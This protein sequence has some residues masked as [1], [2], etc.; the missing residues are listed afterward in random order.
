MFVVGDLHGELGKLNKELTRVGFDMK[1]EHL[2]SVGDLVDRGE[3]SLGCLSLLTQEWFHAVRGNHEQMMIDAV[4]GHDNGMAACW[5]MNGGVW[6]QRLDEKERKQANDLISN[7]AAK[8]PYWIEVHHRGRVIVVCHA[9]WPKGDYILHGKVDSEKI[10]W[11]RDRIKA[12]VYKHQHSGIS[13][14]DLFVFGH[15]PLDEKVY[16]DNCMWIDTGACFGKDLTIVEI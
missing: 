7:Y 16:V 5:F 15:T 6:Y 11:S 13:G 2:F 4:V 8:L 3:D 10:I 9:D 12:L 14:A 1:T